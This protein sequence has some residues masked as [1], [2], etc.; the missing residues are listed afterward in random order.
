MKYLRKF[1]ESL[2]EAKELL[3]IINDMALDI[4]DKDLRV[5]TTLVTD[6]SHEIDLKIQSPQ[7]KRMFHIKEI[8]N[9]LFQIIHFM[10]DQEWNVKYS[11]ACGP[12]FSHP[13]YLEDDKVI[14][15]WS[16]GYSSES[17]EITSPITE[18]RIVFTKSDEYSK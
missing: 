11:N 7:H 10:K 17:W 3:S 1:N 2:S 5:T 14:G 18:I 12:D 15:K 9:D 4:K 6:D 13:V 16:D 8:N